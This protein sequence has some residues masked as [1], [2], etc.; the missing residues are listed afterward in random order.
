MTEQNN[1]QHPGSGIKALASNIQHPKK[2]NIYFTA[3]VPELQDTTEVL[4]I[5]QSSG[6]EM[7]E[8]GMPYSDPVADGPVIQK[9]HELALKNG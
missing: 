6:A 4:K 5:I 7:V 2:L 3:G 1:I 8:I 9:A